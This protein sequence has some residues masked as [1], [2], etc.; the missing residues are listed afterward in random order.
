MAE[1]FTFL[2]LSSRDSGEIDDFDDLAQDEI[3]VDDEF[4]KKVK[5]DYDTLPPKISRSS[6]IEDVLESVVWHEVAQWPG[7]QT[8]EEVAALGLKLKLLIP[9]E[10]SRYTACSRRRA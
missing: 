7:F 8:E 3:V 5:A 1:R 4:Q 2:D 10:R 9:S 6:R